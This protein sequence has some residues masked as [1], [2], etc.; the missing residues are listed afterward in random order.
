[1]ENLMQRISKQAKS[2]KYILVAIT[3]LIFVQL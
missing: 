1:M 3:S 2:K